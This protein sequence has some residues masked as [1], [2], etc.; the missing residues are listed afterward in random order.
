MADDFHTILDELLNNN[1][2]LL[3]KLEKSAST[4]A[5]LAVLVS[6]AHLAQLEL[7]TD[8]LLAWLK[9]ESSQ[10]RS[11]SQDELEEIAAGKRYSNTRVMGG[12]AARIL[13][14][15]SKPAPTVFGPQVE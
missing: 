10:E 1:D 12:A 6:A 14:H 11:L 15:I 5:A 2:E 9:E 3:D 7:D 13:R 4:D 8:Q